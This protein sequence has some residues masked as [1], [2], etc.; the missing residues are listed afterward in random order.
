MHDRVRNRCK[1]AAVNALKALLKG[2]QSFDAKQRC[3]NSGGIASVAALLCNLFFSLPIKASI[4]ECLYLLLL[5]EMDSAQ[6]TDAFS[7]DGESK[8]KRLKGG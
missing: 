6:P 2:P 5:P 3:I 8:G 7:I 4:A 1:A